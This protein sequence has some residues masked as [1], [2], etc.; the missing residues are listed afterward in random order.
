MELRHCYARVNGVTLHYVTAGD[1]PPV[2]LLHGFPETHRSWDLQLPCLVRAGFRVIAPDLRGYGESSRPRGG[3]DL[4][5]LVRDVVELG[6]TVTTDPVRW[7]GHD[8]GGAITWQIATQHPEAVDRAVVIA[9]AHPYLMARALRSDLG[10]LRKSWYMFF[11]QLPVL[12]ELWLSR[13]GAKNLGAL[14]RQ[15]PGADRAPRELVQA[16]RASV[17]RIAP[18][19]APLAYYRTA[20]RRGALAE[21]RGERA[22]LPEVRAPMTLIWAEHDACF[23]SSLAEEHRRIVPDLTLHVLPGTGHFAHQ[24]APETVNALLLEALGPSVAANARG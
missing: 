4:D 3:Y 17:G 19:A 9:C 7:V 21:L 6:R 24:E 16:A 10:Q 18:L 8:W 15:T 13:R 14:F 2:L 22:P 11:F 12:P 23:V 5:T 1:G 20:I